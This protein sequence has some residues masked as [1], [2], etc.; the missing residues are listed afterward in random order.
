MVDQAISRNM[1][2]SSRDIKNVM[3]IYVA[4]W[5]KG[6][7]TTYYLHMKPNHTAEQSTISVNKS[8]AIGK[9]GFG[10][11]FANKSVPVDLL[12]D[13][14]KFQQSADV[15]TTFV[16]EKAEIE[17]LE[18]VAHEVIT[19]ETPAKV[20][21]MAQEE[22]THV[23]QPKKPAPFAAVSGK[24]SGLKIILPD[25]PQNAFICEGCE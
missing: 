13:T 7:K 6:L 2:L 3:D 16:A 22:L 1:Y 15:S 14:P 17:S 23:E 10:A 24:Q 25:D 8:T 9:S 18:E 20:V 12:S 19:Q 4:A 21:D 11:L 5:E